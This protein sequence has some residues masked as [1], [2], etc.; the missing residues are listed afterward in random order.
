MITDNRPQARLRLDAHDHGMVLR[1]GDGPE[2]C[3]RDVARE[4]IIFQEDGVYHLFYDG[5]GGPNGWRVCLATSRDL[6]HWEK[7]GPIMD[8]GEPGEMDSAAVVSPWVIQS[9]GRWHMFYIGTPN[10][11]ENVPTFPYLTFK[12][13]SH[14]LGGPWTKQKGLIPFKTEENTYHSITASAGHI[15]QVGDEFRMFFSCTTSRPGH[16]CVLRTIGIARTHDLDSTWTL[17]PQPALPVDEQI[18]N[19]SLYYEPANGLWFLFTNHI[20][21]QDYEYT[22]AV[23]VYW[24]NDLDHWDPENKAV[25]LDQHNCTWAKTSIGMPSVIQVGERLALLYDACPG[26][27]MSNWHRDIGLAWLNLPLVPPARTA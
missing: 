20:T 9:G 18:E 19:T 22:D 12:A 7:H 1:H 21:L 13:Y 24:T 15:V 14:S 17:D 27:E 11:Y 2:G 23:W 4:A 10:L 16:D 25:V 8:L 26:T 5:G 6:L 3:D